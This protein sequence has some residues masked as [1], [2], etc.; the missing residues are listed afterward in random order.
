MNTINRSETQQYWEK[1]GELY[2]K[3]G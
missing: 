2:Y 1:T 3:L